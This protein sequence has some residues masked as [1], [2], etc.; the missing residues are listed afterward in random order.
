[1]KTAVAFEELIGGMHVIRLRSP[2]I[3]ARRRA[4]VQPCG[5]L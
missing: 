2:G 4:S 5:L 3:V 1:V